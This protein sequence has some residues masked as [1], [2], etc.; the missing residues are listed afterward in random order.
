MFQLG[1]VDVFAE[2]ST[3][4][5]QLRNEVRSADINLL[6]DIKD[7][8]T[9]KDVL[10]TC[11]WHKGGQENT[12]SC[13][14]SKYDKIRNGR[15]I[16]AGSVHCF[17]CGQIHSLPELVSY[18]LGYSTPDVG[19]R[20]ILQKFN[21]IAVESR[22]GLD[23]DFTRNKSSVQNTRFLDER[24]LDKYRY[25]SDYLYIERKFNDWTIQLY[26]LGYDPATN[27]ITIPI[28]DELGRLVF[29]KRRAIT[30]DHNARFKNEAGVPKQTILYGLPQ[31]LG[32][33]DWIESGQCNN[34]ELIYNYKTYG[35]A[36]VEGEFNA[37][38][39]MQNNML[40]VSMLGRILFEDKSKKTVMQ[41]ELLLRHGI[42]NIL[43]WTDN[44]KPGFEAHEKI[45][46]Q[47]K[48]LFRLST[49]DYSQ[50]PQL[51]DANDYSPEQLRQQR[52]IFY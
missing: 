15:T 27:S 38:Y 5:Q 31:V 47:L 36:L 11:P 9:A 21:G 41:K 8:D 50:F 37:C 39:L 30:K 43:L 23:L 3:V 13:G 10:I 20:W 52:F 46:N 18:C 40:A 26:E 44:D 48:G 34:Q 29:I 1:E 33:I 49:P 42:R 4:I 7:S 6:K 45:S 14:V 28:R 51:N 12:P 24:E 32:M 19:R 2:V 25:T 16:P 22:R 35:V 17:T